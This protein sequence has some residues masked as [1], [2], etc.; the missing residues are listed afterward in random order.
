MSHSP[1]LSVATGAGA[2]SRC[3]TTTTCDTPN[4]LLSS[5]RPPFVLH[6]ILHSFHDLVNAFLPPR[7][8]IA[9]TIFWCTSATA[10][11]A[12]DCAAFQIPNGSS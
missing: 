6:P 5:L 8:P 7:G 1:R 4:M 10:S 3:G 11:R 2:F 9:V 12:H